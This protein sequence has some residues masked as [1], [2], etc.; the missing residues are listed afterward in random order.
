VT[1]LSLALAA[2]PVA[3]SA[4]VMC[5]N[6]LNTSLRRQKLPSSA[7]Q[8]TNEPIVDGTASLVYLLAALS[9]TP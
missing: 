7:P 8:S 3:D 1:V 6:Q 9:P 5:V 4:R 2:L